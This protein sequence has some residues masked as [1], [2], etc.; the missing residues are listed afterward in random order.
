MAAEPAGPESGSIFSRIIDP[1]RPFLRVLAL[2][3]T[4]VAITTSVAGTVIALQRHGDTRPTRVR[5]LMVS[6]NVLGSGFGD[7]LNVTGTV[8]DREPD[9]QLWLVIATDRYYPQERI[10]LARDG[11]WQAE[12]YLGDPGGL[13]ASYTF[14]VLVVQ[15][16]AKGDK[17]LEEHVG[18]AVSTRNFSGMALLPARTQ[19]LAARQLTLPRL[20]QQGGRTQVG[21]A[22]TPRPSAP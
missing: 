12:V 3:G 20:R 10:L 8:L 4:V 13:P 9:R 18:G 14:S 1:N 5:D 22:S 15:V 6:P 7:P 2:I 16:D 11:P 19:Q 17:E 21:D